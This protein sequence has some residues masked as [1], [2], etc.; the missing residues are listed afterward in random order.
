[1]A[2]GDGDAW[3]E[4]TPVN[5]TNLSDGDDHVR[6]LRKGTRIRLEYEH[7][8]LAGSSAGGKH[9][10]MTMQTQGTKPTVDA[11][12]VAALYVKDVGSGVIELYYEDEA[13]NEVQMT[14]GSALVGAVGGL[15]GAARNLLVVYTSATQ[16]T[17]TADEVVVTTSANVA[18]ILRSVSV[19][20]AITSSGANGLDTGAE[21]AN[22]IYYLWVIY[23]PATDTTA[24]LISASSSS[25]TLPSGYTYSALVS[26][27]GNNNSS[28]FISFRQRGNKYAFTT[29]ATMAS[30]ST[31]NVLTTVDLTPANMTTNAGFVPSALSDWCYG[32]VGQDNATSGITNIT[33]AT[34]PSTVPLANFVQ[35][36]S[37]NPSFA[38]SY[39][40]FNV[41]TADSLFWYSNGTG[42][43]VFLHGFELNKTAL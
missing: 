11:T 32:T 34:V 3:D 20:G 36:H 8:T 1:M 17:I 40:Q 33:G 39:W 16:A 23:N 25:P 37:E 27:V 13:G 30:G 2:L 7:S 35:P 15:K 24:A 26:C 21:A 31:S 9:K 29:W 42:D 19:V 14:D 38:S 10:F 22:T 6:D 28:D 43:A 12:Q 5:A 4:T 41:I 18:K